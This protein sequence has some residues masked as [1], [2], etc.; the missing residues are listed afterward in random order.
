VA[1]PLVTVRVPPEMAPL[2]EVAQDFVGRYFS[3]PRFDPTQG[4]I[5]IYG[6]RYMLVRAASMSVEFFDRI[7]RL[8]ADKGTEEAAAVAR[9]LLFDIAHALGSAD[10]RNFHARMS[11]RDPIARLSAGPVHFAYSGWAFVDISP[12][13]TPTPDEDFFLLYDHP[14]SFES[15]SWLRAG[16]DVDFGVCIMNAGYSSGWCEESF[17]VT[18]V[19][20][21]ILCQAKGDE[22]CRF[23]MAHPARIEGAVEAYLK[24]EPEVARRVTGYEIPG[25]FARK[26]AEEEL[27]AAKEAAENAAQA[28]A[29][30]LANMSHEIRTP[31]NA[32]LGMTS[33]LADTRLDPAQQD[34]VEVIRRSCEHLLTLINDV[35]DFSKIEADRLALE[36]QEF[37]LCACVE[38]AFELVAGAAAEKGLELACSLEPD[39]PRTVVAD[40]GRLRQILANLL[41]NAVKFT[42]AGEVVVRVSARPLGGDRHELTV[43]VRDT[44]IGMPPDAAD[45]LFA[46]FTQ[47]DASTTRV[48]G[49]TG[50]G[51]AI[52]RRLC[53]L[54]GGDLRVVSTPGAGSEFAC[55]VQVSAAAPDPAE[56]PARE[57][58]GV[59][60]LLV[61]DNETNRQILELLARR[62]GLQVRATHSPTEALGWVEAGEAFDVAVLDHRMPEMDG[63]T[64]ATRLRE[65]RGRDDLRLVLLTAI[66]A[67]GR[68]TRGRAD[69][70][71]VL[72]KPVKQSQIYDVLLGVIATGT[73]PPAPAAADAFDAGLAE[74]LPLQIL[75]VEDN[76]INQKLARLMLGRYGYD[77]DLAANGLEAVE[78]LD[79]RSY[80]VILMDVQM[81]VLDGCEATRRIRRRWGSSPWIIAMTANALAGDRDA[82]LDAGMD[83]YLGKP[84]R[85]QALGAALVRAG[86]GLARTS[87]DVSALDRLK[88]DLGE[89]APGLLP[90]L[91]AE[92]LNDAARLVGQ[93]RTGVAAGDGAEARRVAHTLRSTALAFGATGLADACAALEAGPDAAHDALAERI[94]QEY[95]RVAAALAGLLG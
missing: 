90:E 10:A 62:W 48:Y 47:A 70:S 28:K 12:Q 4:T 24:R 77:A 49:G 87:V 45:R 55:T 33:L 80:D 94:G 25:F 53:E 85:P 68:D 61:D 29:A 5:E 3:E 40:P 36:P 95:D 52:S 72:T 21:E 84:V 64:L 31:M 46:P 65:L 35:L 63:V 74:R 86:E 58:A 66:G 73:A 93:V 51:L 75:L 14:Y 16:K 82:C 56:A 20:T 26:Q 42:D 38:E 81:P 32:V 88:A 39:V 60:L 1:D 30:F 57:L 19:A 18:L 54:M 7:L 78:A 59:R 41:S 83:D 71:A 27:H 79:A 37:D 89:E 67:A 23:V 8:Y 17:G 22:H 34:Y 13:S 76:P 15:H 69:F 2:F 50:L 44:G 11:L 6:Q 91:V 9:S 92:F 43:T